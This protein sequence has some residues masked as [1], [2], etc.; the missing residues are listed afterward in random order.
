M[1]ITISKT[2]KEEVELPKFWE[3]DSG[4]YYHKLL[5]DGNVLEVAYNHLK[6]TSIQGGA[7]SG[8]NEI[9]EET[10]NLKLNEIKLILNL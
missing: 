8:V 1:K 4:S 10:F 9:S 3:S 5:D 7:C 6:L 2:I